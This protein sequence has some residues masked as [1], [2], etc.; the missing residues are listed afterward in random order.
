MLGDAEK[1]R[2]SS[3]R[4]V[5]L[6]GPSVAPRHTG[7]GGAGAGFGGNEVGRDSRQPSGFGGDRPMRSTVEGFARTSIPPMIGT[8]VGHDG[9]AMTDDYTHG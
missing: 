4:E 8:C 7:P 1:A 3:S 9:L 6:S 5:R 2:Q